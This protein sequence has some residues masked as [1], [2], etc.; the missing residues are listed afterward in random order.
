MIRNRIIFIGTWLA[1]AIALFV[2]PGFE[3]RGLAW[4]MIVGYWPVLLLEHICDG[5]NFNP[6]VILLIMIIL[7]GVTVTF[8]AWLMDKSRISKKVVPLLYCT[9]VAL[10][11]YFAFSGTDYEEWQRIPA[12]AAAME[13]SEVNYEPTRWDFRKSIVIPGVLAGGLMGLYIVS[14]LGAV[15]ALLELWHQGVRCRSHRDENN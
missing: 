14:G 10:A 5:S 8:F 7:S 9:M 12:I 13:S 15:F 1:F 6:F 3:V 11:C 4:G 2:F